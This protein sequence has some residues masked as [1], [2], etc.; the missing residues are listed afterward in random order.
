MPPKSKL[1]PEQMDEIRAR[2][3]ADPDLTNAGLAKEYGVDASLISRL[4]HGK[5]APAGDTPAPAAATSD[6]ALRRIPLLQI[7]P[8]L[9]N[10][11]RTFD[12]EGIRDLAA[13]IAAQGLLQNLVVRPDE[14]KPDLFRIVAGERRWRALEL[15]A[16]EARLPIEIRDNGVPVRIIQAD[17]AQ[18]LALALLE[19][20]QRV[21]VNPMEEAAA[22]AQ[23]QQLDPAKWTTRTIAEAIGKPKGQRF[24]QQR[25]ALVERLAPEI[26][27]ALRDGKITFTHARH[28]TMADFKQQ[29]DLLKKGVGAWSAERLREA[30]TGDLVPVSRAVFEEAAYTGQIVENPETG[31][32]Y[33][34]D[35]KQF[36]ELQRAAAKAKAAELKKV[37]AWAEFEESYSFSHYRYDQVDDGTAGAVVHFSNYSGIVEI[38]KGLAKRENRHEDP[39]EVE[40]RRAEQEQQEARQKACERLR[41]DLQPLIASDPAM[42]MRLY[43]Y[44]LGATH[45]H[46]SPARGLSGDGLLKNLVNGGALS[47]LA[48]H[49]GPVAQWSGRHNFKE[50]SD[51]ATIWAILL[52][53]PEEAM[54]TAIAETIAAGFNVAYWS[55]GG[56]SPLVVA[57]A[58]H[59][60][61]AIPEI[62]LPAQRDIED[63]AIAASAAAE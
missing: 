25:L 17:A 26:Q 9:L 47:K 58:R 33:F 2:L 35:K 6:P 61:V 11:R 57:L 18:H 49:V 43:F 37:W 62:L 10:P 14:E 24:V 27:Q 60:Q 22:F 23:L 41:A 20:L 44:E 4:R 1:T 29:R 45:R 7:Q 16:S 21:D 40:R 50:D 12:D 36:M 15:M 56:I 55:E 28:L 34:A 52:Q 13:S 30:I 54:A 53:M 63:A 42:A 8:S 59:Y 31:T 3:A 32:R 51:P 38:H 5:Y 48:G 46:K 39:A 19:N